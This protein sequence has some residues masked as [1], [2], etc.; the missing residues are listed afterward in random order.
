MVR[1]VQLSHII[2]C[3]TKCISKSL[4]YHVHIC[5]SSLHI[6]TELQFTSLCYNLCIK[7]YMKDLFSQTRYCMN[8]AFIVL[9]DIVHRLLGVLRYRLHPPK[10]QSLLPKWYLLVYK[11]KIAKDSLV[12]H[13][14]FLKFISNMSQYNTSY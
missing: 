9:S 8:I 4:A 1:E 14:S 12:K 13:T 3:L 2:C 10:V 5:F 11:I 6:L 7:S